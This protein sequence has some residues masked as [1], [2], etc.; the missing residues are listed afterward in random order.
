MMRGLERRLFRLEKRR[1]RPATFPPVMFTLFDHAHSGVIAAR[2]AE[3]R[4]ARLPGESVEELT[5][6]A[7]GV[8]GERIMWAEY[9]PS[10]FL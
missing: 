6:R 10:V 9:L 7:A 5:Q 1:R 4:V 3:A 2:T 8:I